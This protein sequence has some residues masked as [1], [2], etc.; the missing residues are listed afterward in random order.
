MY[1]IP[2]L[3]HHN[4]IHVLIGNKPTRRVSHPKYCNTHIVHYLY[5][6]ATFNIQKYFDSYSLISHWKWA[7]NKRLTCWMHLQTLYSV[8]MIWKNGSLYCRLLYW[9]GWYANWIE[10]WFL[11][12]IFVSGFSSRI[13][14]HHQKFFLSL[15]IS[16]Y[17]SI[18]KA[19]SQIG[20][21]WCNV[22][23]EV[24]RRNGLTL[25]SWKFSSAIPTR[26]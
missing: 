25:N 22:V 7:N 16:H 4:I 8:Y 17:N 1:H 10:N 9:R 12:L 18:V 21:W 14:G 2:A 24:S 19:E 5:R 20:R 6:I 23:Y 26:G 13:H 11:K 15:T 3:R